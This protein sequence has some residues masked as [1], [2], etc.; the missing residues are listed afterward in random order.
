MSSVGTAAFQSSLGELIAQFVAEKRA[1]GYRYREESRALRAFDAYL[2]K[3]GHKSMDLPRDV[4]EGWTCRA[5][6]ET[7]RNHEH[8]QRLVQQFGRFLASRGFTVYLPDTRGRARARASFVPYIFTRDEIVR[9]L[10][11]AEHLPTS[12][13]APHRH[14]VVPEVFQLLCCCGLRL[15]EA[16]HLRRSDVDLDQGVLTIRDGKFQKDRLVPLPAV[17]HA[18]LKSYCDRVGMRRADSAF[19]PGP[20]GAPY[21]N[22]GMYKIFRRLLRDSGI[23]HGGRGRGPRIH[24]LR[25]SFAVHRLEA[26]YREGADLDAKL[27]LL[28]TYLG[29]RGLQGTQVYLRLTPQ[30]FPD[31]SSRLEDHLG[32]IIPGGG[33]HEAD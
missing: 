18:R 28:A 2:Q 4:V 19:F 27:P 9:L 15:G 10:T 3:I 21:S 22:H 30:L 8:R 11:A 12:T 23:P 5:A 33:H 29:H 32:H 26:W 31:V 6:N 16:L 20:Y 13:L 17:A 7:P 1:C 14:V 25:H 24:D